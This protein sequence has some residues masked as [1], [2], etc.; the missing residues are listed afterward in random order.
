MIVNKRISL[1]LPVI[2]SAVL[3]FLAS[4]I[5]TA[6][7]IVVSGADSVWNLELTPVSPDVIDSTDAPEENLITEAFV[8]HADSV[9][10]LDLTSPSPDVL[11]SADAPSEN[12]ITEAFVAHADSIWTTGLE[13]TE[14]NQKWSF[15]I[16]TDLHIGRGYP[17]YD[18][19]G[20]EDGYSGEDYYLTKRLENVVKWI[21]DNKNDIDCDGTKCPIQFL[22]VLGDIADSAEKSEF[23]KAKKILDKLND[24]NNDG[25][26]S[27]G[28]PYVPLFGNHDVW[29][30]T[31][32]NN[33]TSA[34]GERYFDQIF[35]DENDINTK[36]MKERLTF[37]RDEVHKNYKNFVF[38]YGKINFVGLDFNSR[39][40]ASSGVKGE[41][42]LHP[43][44]INW[45]KE[46]LSE[47]DGKEPVIIFSHEPFARP[48][49]RTYY[50]I[51]GHGL[52]KFPREEGNFSGQEIE[53]IQRIL[54]DYENLFP[55]QQI[56]ANFGGHIHGFEK[57]G[58]EK[59][60]QFSPVDL[61]F[62]ANWQYPSLS[63]VPVFTTE[64]LMVAGNEKDLSNKGIIRIV[65]VK[66]KEGIDFSETK[67]EIPALNP[68]IS[69]EY[70]VLPD[71]IYPCVYFRAHLFS[72]RDYESLIWQFGDNKSETI[73]YPQIATIHCYSP[74]QVPAVYNVKLTAID[75]ETRKDESITRKVEIKKG[76][77]P[78]I[79]KIGGEAKGK[80]ELISTELD[81]KV[82]EFGRTMADW[83]LA[84]FKHSPSTPV[85]LFKVHFERATEDIDLTQMKVEVDSKKKKSLLYMPKW[86]GV[87]EREKVLFI[88]K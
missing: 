87:I 25:N 69:F 36:L 26:T 67:L 71:Q 16:I 13:K 66:G 24:P 58:K 8:S 85:G 73:G 23:L 56:L 77:I 45:L 72:Q 43:E 86:P 62:D 68:S 76:I 3:L 27:D 54:E 20:F 31:K 15:A 46:K 21:N 61:F 70:K 14:W 41:G 50:E 48:R 83:I 44:T 37:Q 2:L 75:K 52:F 51:F 18:G 55:G 28:I 79:I 30:Y 40:K 47:L 11:D 29:P 17:D 57:F 82:T 49:S 22:A 88:P 74:I 78:K 80:I 10:N 64:A 42:V 35:W 65:K 12:L 63:T 6:E 7:Q 39:E 60:G 81:E 9:L 1:S 34:L 84:K 38:N 53:K 19:Q 5:V 4:S 33:A 59:I 32:S